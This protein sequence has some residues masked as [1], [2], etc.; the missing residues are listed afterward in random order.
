MKISFV[1]PAYN[2]RNYIARCL[3]SILLQPFSDFEIIIIDDGSTDDTFAIIEL[4]VKKSSLIRVFYQTN[5]GQ[6]AARNFGLSQ[7]QGDYV[8]F[9]DSDDWLV[10]SVLPRIVQILNKFKPDVMVVNFEY[11][12][13]NKSIVTTNQLPRHLVGKVINPKLESE[14]FSVVSCWSTPPWRFI[15]RRQHLI[16]A[17]IRFAV[18][19]FYE[20]HP[21]AIKLMLTANNVYVDGNVSYAY[22]QRS[23]STTKVNDK[24]AF[25]FL[26]IRRQCLSL[27]NQFAV[28][29]KLAPIVASYLA[30]AYF[31]SAHVAGPFRLEFINRMASELS[32][33][34]FSFV[35]QHG[36]WMTRLFAEAIRARS[37][38]LFAR[39]KLIYHFYSY[40]S[41]VRAKRWAARIQC[42]LFGR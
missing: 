15:S 14:D 33:K 21:F 19:V 20:D 2:V 37:P 24:K 8:W 30:P 4:Y 34:E 23:S 1:I 41:W 31:Y 11:T 10:E 32:E 42:K 28:Y 12:F 22:Y 9:I 16:E 36:D 6:G 3:D 35:Q 7:A 27:F 40:F 25:D 29:D 26:E 17:D 38:S 39:R 5:S 13:E 18:G